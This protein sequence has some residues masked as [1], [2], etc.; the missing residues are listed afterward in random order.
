[1]IDLQNARI[2][3]CNDDGIDA[4]GIKL[5]EKLAR[6][7]SDDV[8]VVAP[9]IEQSG[10]GHSLTL[11]RPLRIHKR[12]DRHFA[13]DG[14]PTDCILLAL[15]IIMR[16]T[17]PD[18]VFSGINRGG[19]LGEDV[20]YSGT[21]AAAM[22]AALLNVPAIA[23]SQY[24]SQKL[25]SWDIA[26]AHLT[27]VAR[28]LVAAKWPSNV[29]IN[30]NFPEYE[31]DGGAQ[32]C[33]TRQGQRKIGDHVAERLDPRG[34]PYYWIGA[35]RSELPEDENADLHV[36]EKGDISITPIGLDFT[37]NKT[38]EKLTKAFQ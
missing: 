13:V 11:R 3:I 2:L 8:W 30:V 16:E 27:Q 28:S 37:D 31:R 23:F 12:D 25:I 14:T 15:Q 22:E 6:Q 29:L 7:F 24:F 32:V 5:L 17:P 20:T 36:I 34:E 19:N 26:R 35:I 18:I 10:A 38:H 1:M 9:S 33:V 4:P 21:V